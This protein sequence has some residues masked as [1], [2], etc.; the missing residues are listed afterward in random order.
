MCIRKVGTKKTNVFWGEEE[1]ASNIKFVVS[2]TAKVLKI[3]T[4]QNIRRGGWVIPVCGAGS[5]DC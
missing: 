4:A 2:D 5:M 1:N 3:V